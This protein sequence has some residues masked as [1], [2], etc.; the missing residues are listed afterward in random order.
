MTKNQLDY[1]GLEETKRSNL[2]RETETHRNNLATETEINRSNVAREVETNRHNVAT[3]AETHR[4]NLVGEQLQGQR[5]EEEG[6]HNRAVEQETER[7]NNLVARGVHERNVLSYAGT[8]YSADTQAR[9]SRATARTAAEAT[10]M[11]AATSAN[12]AKYSADRHAEASKYAA[13]LQSKTSLTS[14]EIQSLDK[15]RDRLHD[16]AQ[17][18][19]DRAS[20]KDIARLQQDAQTLRTMLENAARKGINDDNLR[21]KINELTVQMSQFEVNTTQKTFENLVKLIDAIIPF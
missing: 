16:A 5:N 15:Y 1:L 20:R 10:K 19:Y 11:A 7:N 13:D 8:K 14:A 6:R 4:S 21:Q 9:T 3:E 18:G 17:K 2:A 12:A